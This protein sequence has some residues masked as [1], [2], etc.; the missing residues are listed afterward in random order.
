LNLENKIISNHIKNDFFNF[1]LVNKLVKK[2]EMIIYD[3]FIYYNISAAR[4]GKIFYLEC[5]NIYRIIG[6]LKRIKLKY[7]LKK[8]EESYGRC[9]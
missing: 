5:Q 6:K 1:L 2:D 9:N 3:L 7:I 8:T 4:L